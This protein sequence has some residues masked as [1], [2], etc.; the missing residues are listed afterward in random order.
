MFEIVRTLCDMPGPGGYEEHVQRFVA[1]AL[2]DAGCEVD[3]TPV[4]NVLAKVGGHGKRA[5]LVAHADEIAVIVRS[6]TDA[7]FLRLMTGGGVLAS[8]FPPSPSLVSQ[9]C[10]VMTADGTVPGVIGAR[11]GHLRSAARREGEA[12]GWDEVFVDLGAQSRAEVEGWGVHPGASVIWNPPETRR[13]GAN[14]VGKAMDDRAA[15]AIA[16]E[17]ARRAE[18]ARL[19]YELWI[20]STIQE[21]GGLIGAD[22]LGRDYGLGIA[23]DVGLV[24]DVPGVSA[25]EVPC[26]LGRGPVLVHKDSSA[27][28]HKGLTQ[29]LLRVAEQADIAV[30]HVAFQSYGSDAGALLKNGIPAALVCYPTRYT[31]SPV[32]TVRERDLEDTVRLLRAFFERAPF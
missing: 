7:G 11:T 6:I 30:Q 28:Y 16:I 29:A 20:A 4:G 27:R 18:P 15:L 12:L 1:G 24:G 23:L 26:A 13:L 10:L 2:Q 9:H 5:V 3:T 21:E 25:E 17:V 19:G 22:G 14:I 32:E 31:H 8:R